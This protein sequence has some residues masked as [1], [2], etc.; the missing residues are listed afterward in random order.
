[1]LKRA[2][3]TALVW[4]ALL[5]AGAVLATSDPEPP[6]TPPPSTFNEFYPEDQSISDCL[7][8][9]QK[10]NCGSDARGGWRQYAVFGA[11]IGGLA[12]I[13]WRI[14]RTARRARPADAHAPVRT[15]D[16]ADA[17]DTCSDDDPTP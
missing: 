14:V 8:L 3:V 15:P 17:D 5:P 9:L 6:A 10:P 2:V 12:F 4:L 13:G 11:L 16:A 7:G 1:M